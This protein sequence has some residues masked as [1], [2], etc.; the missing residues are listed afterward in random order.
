MQLLGKSM[1]PS[2]KVNGSNR[3][4]GIFEENQMINFM[5]VTSNLIFNVY[6]SD[7][8][9]TFQCCIK[10]GSGRLKSSDTLQINGNVLY[11]N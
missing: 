5:S 4:S 10:D 11:M 7:L 2:W 1:D 3:Y 9:G 6:S 8:V